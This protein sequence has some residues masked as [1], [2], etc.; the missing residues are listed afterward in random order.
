MCSVDWRSQGY[1]PFLQ[2]HSR[3]EIDKNVVIHHFKALFMAECSPLLRIFVCSTLFPLCSLTEVV[4]PCHDVCFSVYTACH[5]VYLL[6]HQEWPTFFNCTN[7][8]ARPQVCLLP[9]STTSHFLSPSPP[10]SPL[11]ASS[12]SPTSSSP[13][14]TS[15]VLS[16]TS[17]SSPPF[18]SSPSSSSSSPSQPSATFYCFIVL[19]PLLF[20]ILQLAVK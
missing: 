10:S 19:A 12:P 1:M 9:L 20:L 16:L 2:L 6:H 3:E 17:S 11:F 13:L 18:G 14:P 4:L 15:H 8:P 5:H 7:L